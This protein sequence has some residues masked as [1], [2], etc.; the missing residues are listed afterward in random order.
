MINTAGGLTGGDCFEIDAHAG[1]DSTLVLTTQAAERAYLALN[2]LATMQTRLK[3]GPRSQIMWL[4][5][6]LILYDGSAL[7]RRL[8]IDLAQNARLLMVEP[9][10]FG[11]TAMGEDLSGVHFDDRI[12]IRRDGAP[13]YSDAFRLTPAKTRNLTRAAL[14]N[15]GQAIASVIFVAPEAETHLPQIRALLPETG[16]ASLLAAD[17]LVLRL[18][19]ADGFKLRGALVPILEHLKG[20]PLPRSWSL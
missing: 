15:G 19:A 7:R 9:V 1:T 11:R 8:E 17:T 5:Q 16:G 2:G 3:A 20:T 13:L 6:E 10:I 12:N 14:C 18:V 4:P